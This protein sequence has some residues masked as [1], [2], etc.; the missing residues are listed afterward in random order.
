MK[1]ETIKALARAN[2]YMCEVLGKNGHNVSATRLGKYQERPGMGFVE[3]HREVLSLGLYDDDVSA[4][5]AALVADVDADDMSATEFIPVVKQGTYVL[6]QIHQRSFEIETIRDTSERL[7]V[8]RQ[9]V[10]AMLK[11]GKLNGVTYK[12]ARMVFSYSVDARIRHD[13]ESA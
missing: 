4:M 1:E 12:G 3:L 11:S 9:R 2:K 7:G 13:E 10:Y 6:A 5:I 8:S